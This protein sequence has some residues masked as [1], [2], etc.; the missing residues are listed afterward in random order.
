MDTA[1]DLF[2]SFPGLLYEQP[3]EFLYPNVTAPTKIEQYFE[4]LN[5]S[6]RNNV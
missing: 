6:L 3:Q 4:E 1:T 5:R 2:K